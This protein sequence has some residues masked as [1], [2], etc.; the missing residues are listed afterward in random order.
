MIAKPDTTLVGLDSAGS[1]FEPRRGVGK[2]SMLLLHYTG[3]ET[4]RQG[5]SIGLRAW[6]AG[7]RATTPSTRPAASR[8]W[9][10]RTCAPG[11]PAK[12]S[13]TAR[14]TSTRRPSA[15][16]FT[17]RVTRWATRIFRKPSSGRSR[18]CARISSDG[19]GIRPERVLAH[20][21][22]APTRKKDPGEKF[23]WARLAR[24]GIGH[25]VEPQPVI[26]AE[27]GHG[28]RRGRPAGG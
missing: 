8:R 19:S 4:R 21:D 13:G 26:E 5:R 12:P 10:R 15:S 3:V 14:A 1:Q 23:P 16:R 11:T 27:A 24:A 22:V 17:I 25:W 6:R 2:P 28:H 7:C 18:R 9:W 20:S